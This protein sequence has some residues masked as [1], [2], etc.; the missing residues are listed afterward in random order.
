MKSSGCQRL[1]KVRKGKG[2]VDRS[3]VETYRVPA[4]VIE[5]LSRRT[6]GRT[7]GV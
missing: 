2:D 5:S 4:N 7:R 1:R 3:K 6:E